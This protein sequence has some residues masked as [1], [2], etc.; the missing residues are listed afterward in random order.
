MR[1]S[2]PI[3][4]R[5]FFTFAPVSSQILAISL[6]KDILVANI[7][8]ATYLVISELLTSIRTNLSW[9]DT[10]GAYSFLRVSNISSFSAPITI[11]SGLMQSSTATPSLRNSGF[12]A[13]SILISKFLSF[14]IFSICSLTLKQVPTGTVDLTTTRESF[15]MQFPISLAADII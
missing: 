9:L 4:R 11:R 10:K 13:M 12:E 6:I 1:L 14:M 5:T 8:F 3:P 2:L 7:A 15:N